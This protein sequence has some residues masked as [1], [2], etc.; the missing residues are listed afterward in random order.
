MKIDKPEKDLIQDNNVKNKNKNKDNT[1]N[2][3]KVKEKENKEFTLQIDKID[4]S[5]PHIPEINNSTDTDQRKISYNQNFENYVLDTSTNVSK[6]NNN[7]EPINEPITD[8]TSTNN[9][10]DSSDRDIPEPFIDNNK[11]I[12]SDDLQTNIISPNSPNKPEETILL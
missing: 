12:K 5:T 3:Q 1:I 7:T 6:F 2:D 4:Q 8:P 11:V 9:I 10:E